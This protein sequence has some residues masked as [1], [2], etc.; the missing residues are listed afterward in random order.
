[1]RVFN[2]RQATSGRTTRKS[3]Q[4]KLCVEGC[5]RR[6]LLSGATI[7]GTTERDVAGDGVFGDVA[8]LPGVT[9]SLYKQG[10]STVLEK[11]V[12]DKNGNF[13][14]TNLAVGN[15]FVQQTVPKGYLPTG[16]IPGY[17]VTVK[18]GQTAPGKDFEEY[19]LQPLPTLTNT[20]YTITTPSGHSTKESSLTDLVQP[21][22]TVSVTYGVKTPTTI[23]LVSYSA[24]DGV[25]NTENEQQQTIFSSAT[26]TGSGTE[27]LTVKIP[28]GFFQ[29]D[30]VAGLPIKQLAINPNITYHSQ[31]RFIDGVTGGELI[32]PTT[33]S[34]AVPASVELGTLTSATAMASAPSLE[35]KH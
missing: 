2:F 35:R 23:S 25:F 34:G 21:G 1:M 7:S 19:L 11:A 32:V 16:A 27:T 31:D 10:S 18:S 20:S 9:V 24:P 17:D 8:P 3:T 6:Q 12:S 30:F 33:G 28:E 26:S 29:L 13:S 4:V 15:Y 5:E 14:F 22:D